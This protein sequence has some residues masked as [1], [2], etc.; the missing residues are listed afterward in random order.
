MKKIYIILLLAAFNLQ[1]CKEFLNVKPRDTRVIKNI[2]DYRDLLAPFMSQMKIPNAWSYVWGDYYKAPWDPSI[3][4]L[5]P[6]YIGEIQHTRDFNQ[7]NGGLTDSYKDFY[8]WRDPSTSVLWTKLYSLIGPFNMIIDEIRTAE[9]NDEALRNQVRGEALYWRAYCFFKLVQYYSPY[10]NNEL[11]VPVFLDTHIDAVNGNQSRKTQQE[12]YA[13]IISDCKEGLRLLTLTNP[14]VSW[15]FAYKPSA[16]HALLAAVYH[17]KAMSGAAEESDWTNAVNHA[18]EAML[19]RHLTQNP[20][21]IQDMFDLFEPK[22]NLEN[23]E[24]DLR[25]IKNSFAGTNIFGTFIELYGGQPIDNYNRNWVAVPEIYQMYT[26]TDIRKK[27]YFTDHSPYSPYICNNKYRQSEFRSWNG[28]G[29]IM[30]FR[31]AELYLIKAEALTMSNQLSEARKVMEDFV[32]S[33]YTAAVNIPSGKDEFLQMVYTERKKEFLHEWDINFLDM[34]RLQKRYERNIRGINFVIE[35]DA[36]QYTFPIP[37]Q[38]IQNNPN[39]DVNNPGWDNI[40]Q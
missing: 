27:L 20:Q 32:T 11:G 8:N 5:L 12:A 14:K 4:K 25:V 26:D 37:N 6:G 29:L 30:P 1:S 19:G 3:P 24:F 22:E 35:G 36:F 33:R 17:Y 15:N 38:E 40:V 23:D 7:A 10:K 2:E 16:F 13:Q 18:S 31:L 28:G 39:I 21:D 9:G 34:K